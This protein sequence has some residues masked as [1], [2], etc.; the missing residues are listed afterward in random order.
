[1][2]YEVYAVR[3][4]VAAADTRGSAAAVDASAGSVEK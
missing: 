1:M 2:E 3:T 4:L